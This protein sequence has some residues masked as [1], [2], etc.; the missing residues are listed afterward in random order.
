MRQ[1]QAAIAG[2][3]LAP[4]SA[5]NLRA[6]KNPTIALLAKLHEIIG[7]EAK[8]KTLI[9]VRGSP[10]GGEN[11]QA[12]F[13][14][15]ANPLLRPAPNPLH[16]LAAEHDHSPVANERLGQ[17]PLLHPNIEKRAVL[18]GHCGFQAAFMAVAVLLRRLNDANAGIGENR[19]Q[20]GQPIGRHRI[21]RIEH[22]NHLGLGGGVAQGSIESAS[23]EAAHRL[24]PMK[25]EAWA[26]LGA[27]SLHRQDQRFV[28][29]V[30]DQH[31]HLI[32]GII[33][34]GQRAKR[35]AQN[36]RPLPAGGNMDRDE[37]LT[38]VIGPNA[39]QQSRRPP[40]K[41]PAQHIGDIGKGHA[42]HQCPQEKG[43]TPGGD[44]SHRQIF[45]K[46]TRHREPGRSPHDVGGNRNRQRKGGIAAPAGANRERKQQA[47]HHRDQGAGAVGGRRRDSA[48]QRPFWR[49][50]GV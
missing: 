39:G 44:R 11:A 21:I 27:Q 25:L 46:R 38:A 30:V 49:A 7:S 12:Q 18:S 14:I 13:G 26:K 3:K 40:G 33:H 17:Q 43:R 19:G 9:G 2:Q 6:A 41:H 45:A 4:M 31:H 15:L 36:L 22:R 16:G 23:L 42:K 5:K 48:G 37:R 28:F 10:T 20:L 1:R 34:P 32:G 24:V 35:F 50:I 8:A 47:H 29:G